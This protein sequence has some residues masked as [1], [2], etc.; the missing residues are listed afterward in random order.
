MGMSS[1]AAKWVDETAVVTCGCGKTYAPIS[2]AELLY[3]GQTELDD[4]SDIELRNC[5]CCST[6]AA[7]VIRNH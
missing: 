6:I 3:V 5:T 1:A 2:W 4:T 7:E